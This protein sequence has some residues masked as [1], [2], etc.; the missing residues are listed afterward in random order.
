MV[1]GGGREV[2]GA[3]IRLSAGPGHAILIP[4][5]QL[6]I[7]IDHVLKLILTQALT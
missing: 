7:F 1:R 4:S 3:L 2:K 6:I 5:P